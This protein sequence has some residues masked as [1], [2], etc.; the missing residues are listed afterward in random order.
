[1]GWIRTHGRGSST[2][3]GSVESAAIPPTWIRR[4]GPRGRSGLHRR[5]Q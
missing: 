1:L 3:F 4:K 2:E 5:F